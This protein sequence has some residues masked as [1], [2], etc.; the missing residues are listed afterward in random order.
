VALAASGCVETEADVP[1]GCRLVLQHVS[2]LLAPSAGGRLLFHDGTLG[3]IRIT[4]GFRIIN[5]ATCEYNVHPMWQ[6]ARLATRALPQGV[7]ED[8]SGQPF[9]T[10]VVSAHGLQSRVK[11]PARSAV[12]LK[13][14]GP[15]SSLKRIAVLPLGDRCSIRMLLHKIEYDG[16]CYP[17]DLTRTTS[18]A[19]V[20]DM[21]ATGFS[22]MWNEH[23]LEY[24]HEAGRI[25]HKKWHGLSFAHEVEDGDDPVCNFGPV[26]ARMAKRYTGRAARFDYAA[27]HADSVLF[28]RTGIASRG[29]VM[30]LL[31]RVCAR[32]P[33]IHAN[34]VLIS[35]QPSEEFNGMLGVTHVREHFDPD[36]MYEDL[37]YWMN[38]AHRF[39]CILD[40]LGVSARSLY[41]CPNNLKEAEKE[42]REALEAQEA[43][44][45]AEAQQRPKG[46]EASQQPKGGEVPILSSSEVS[47][48]SHSNLYELEAR[49][50]GA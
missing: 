15:L 26:A 7:Y 19:D 47:K 38:C 13:R 23:L 22:D 48:F 37:G 36:R 21:V 16:P 41:W 42:E 2:G 34:L 9:R 18:L 5:Q 43:E 35:D 11:V 46:G 4:D 3:I 40:G 27:K 17:F 6:A 25:M 32:F 50:L 29:E 44:A 39:R 8:G 49:G 28:L 12:Q 14:T 10:A 33:G 20:A 1:S 45:R 31:T 30:D 24:N